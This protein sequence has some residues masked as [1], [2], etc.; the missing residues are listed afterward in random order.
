LSFHSIN[1]EVMW[2]GMPCF[3]RVLLRDFCMR[4]QIHLVSHLKKMIKETPYTW[5]RRWWALSFPFSFRRNSFYS[6]GSALKK[7]LHP[8]QTSSIFVTRQF[9][10]LKERI[11][12]SLHPG[13]L[14]GLLDNLAWVRGFFADTTRDPWTALEFSFKGLREEKFGLL[15]PSQSPLLPRSCAMVF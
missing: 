13:V 2:N 5:D 8:T 10:V 1:R 6:L 9:K 4:F 3:G 7:A 15:S 14:C 11:D 12:R